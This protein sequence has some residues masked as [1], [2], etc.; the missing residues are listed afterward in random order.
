MGSGGT[1][2]DSNDMFDPIRL[3][4]KTRFIGTGEQAS[5]LITSPQTGQMAFITEDY[6]GF[7]HDKLHVRDSTNA[8][9]VYAN[10]DEQSEENVGDQST[11]ANGSLTKKYYNFTTLPTTYKFYIITGLEYRA[12]STPA[13]V[14]MGVDIVNANPPTN[15]H[16]VLVALARQHTGVVLNTLYRVNEVSSR[17]I[18]GGTILGYWCQ[19][20]A[21]AAIQGNNVLDGY[22]KD[23]TYSTTPAYAN[24]TAFQTS[25]LIEFPSLKMYYR[26]YS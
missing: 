5:N 8:S 22:Y 10:V 2:F 9:W 20:S 25:G 21:A 16:S 6:S 4:Q 19:G 7:K 11:G 3:N 26:G 13:N 17:L 1:E 18:R 15:N 14:M 24:I 12:G 23:D